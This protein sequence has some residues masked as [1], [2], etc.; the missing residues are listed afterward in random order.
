M[1]MVYVGEIALHRNHE[2]RSN[3]NNNKHKIIFLTNPSPLNPHS[4]LRIRTSF[5][6]QFLSHQDKQDTLVVKL[7]LQ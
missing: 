3:E 5:D 7:L 6:R 2:L 4:Y 1:K